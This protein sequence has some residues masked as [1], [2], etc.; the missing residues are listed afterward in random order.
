MDKI[1]LSKN[2]E[3]VIQDGRF[4]IVDISRSALILDRP[5]E[6]LVS[7]L[8]KLSAPKKKA[9][10]INWHN[11]AIKCSNDIEKFA[12][13]A[14]LAGKTNMRLPSFWYNFAAASGKTDMDH[15]GFPFV[16]VS[17][18]IVDGYS[19]CPRERQL[20]DFKNI[21]AQ[22]SEKITFM[23]FDV[24][25]RGISLKIGCQTFTANDVKRVRNF[26]TNLKYKG[27]I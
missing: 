10:E 18:G 5:V 1:K 3:L 12:A 25:N 9:P 26:L 17:V 13:M 22:K 24:L 11:V 15:R 19:V 8:E 23:G 27:S 14:F 16:A 21:F 7:F 4:R 20:M 6:S 2:R